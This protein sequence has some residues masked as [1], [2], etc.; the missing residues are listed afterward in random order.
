MHD[1][2]SVGNVDGKYASFNEGSTA[3]IILLHVFIEFYQQPVNLQHSQLFVIFCCVHQPVKS[4]NNR[5]AATYRSVLTRLNL[6]IGKT[7]HRS[8]S[9]YTT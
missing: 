7:V 8:T 9:H 1:K 6:S 3:Y 5:I 4:T 2:L